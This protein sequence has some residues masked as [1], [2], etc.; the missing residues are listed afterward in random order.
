MKLGF[1]KHNYIENFAV[2]GMIMELLILATFK[3]LRGDK[4]MKIKDIIYK[5]ENF[6]ING[7][8]Q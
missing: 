2:I 5:K 1:I 8:H 4:L 3:Y 7:R 6:R